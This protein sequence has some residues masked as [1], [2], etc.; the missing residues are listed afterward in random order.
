VANLPPFNAAGLLPPG[1]YPQT[2]GELET[3]FLVAGPPNVRPWDVAWRRQLVHNLAHLVDQLWRVGVDEIFVDGS[4]VEDKPHPEDIDGYFVCGINELKSGSLVS[5]LNAL[6][7]TRCWTW[8]VRHPHPSSTK[9]QLP[10]W[11]RYRVELYPHV[12][13]PSGIRDERGH[14]M[15]FP[16]AFRQQRDTRAEKGIIRVERS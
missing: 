5:A 15:L 11:H 1:D 16:S 8:G 13:Q 10:M 12:G 6:E 7:P 14:Q 9:A 4:F 2:L 3:S